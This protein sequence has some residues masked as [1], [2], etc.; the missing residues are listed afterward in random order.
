MTI[1]YKDQEIEAY[2]LIMRKE[3]AL[4]ILR[5]KKTIEIRKFSGK[6]EK[7][8]TAVSYTHL[9]VYKRQS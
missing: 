3:K 2:P 6:Y 8:F 1:K 9:D 7:M 5:G 4:D